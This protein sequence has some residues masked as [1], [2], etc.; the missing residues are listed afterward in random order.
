MD[1]KK[2]RCV[3]I[4]SIA[5][6]MVKDWSAIS[7]SLHL[8]RFDGMVEELRTCKEVINFVRH[9]PT[10]DLLLKHTGRNDIKSGFEYALEPSDVIFIVGLK[11]RTPVSGADVTVEPEDLLIYRAWIDVVAPTVEKALREGWIEM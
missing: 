11:T 5:T 3:V 7:L 10:V 1:S 6:S 9:K 4:P 8:T 2:A